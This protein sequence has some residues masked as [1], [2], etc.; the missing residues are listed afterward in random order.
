MEQ[1]QTASTVF[2]LGLAAISLYFCY[3]IAKPFF[4]PI[5]LAVVFGV[6][7]Q[8]IHAYLQSRIRSR[9]AAALAST[10]LVILV[11]LVATVGVGTIVSREIAGFHLFRETGAEQ[12]L[13]LRVMD[14]VDRVLGWAGRYVAVPAAD[15][16]AKLLQYLQ[17]IPQS[18]LSWAA[19]ALG[20]V[21]A[22]LVN[23]FIALFTL[24]FLLR[25]GAAI[26]ERL[27]AVLPLN[28]KQLDRLYHGISDSIIAN[29][30]GCLA[31]GAA[32]GSLTTLGFWVAGLP[33][34][35]LWG[36]VTGLFSLVPLIGSAA[37][38]APASIILMVGGHWVK[39]LL[40]FGWGAV[41][42]AQVDNLVRPYVIG[43]RA[44]LP[45]VLVFFGLLGG[46]RAFGVL[47]IITGPVI[48]SITAVVFD[49]LAETGESSSWL[50]S[51]DAVEA[52]EEKVKP[53]V[54]AGA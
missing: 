10:G 28:S 3:V 25:D 54:R 33:A 1:K 2:L 44:K 38:W 22:F 40:L 23:L 48:V 5:F 50:R 34:P 29:V 7:F 52:E 47:G 13:S 12:S 51:T 30:H 15:V 20:N 43:R 41:V 19:Q 45:T 14:T 21:G 37:V 31:V 32:Q 17:Q 24:F 16:R 42:V 9:N 8:P 39:G 49:L 18:L 6:V 53:S 26:W 35:V 46:V 36:V 27:T 4:E 11:F